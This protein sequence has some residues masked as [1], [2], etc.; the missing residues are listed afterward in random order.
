[1]NRE[2]NET[3]MIA[4]VVHHGRKVNIVRPPT[5]VA[6]LDIINATKQSSGRRIIRMPGLAAAAGLFTPAVP[7]WI[8]MAMVNIDCAGSD[9]QERTSSCGVVVF[10]PAMGGQMEALVGFSYCALL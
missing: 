9:V 6:F 8:S 5:V 10:F 4:R 2:S 7:C 3:K 1:M